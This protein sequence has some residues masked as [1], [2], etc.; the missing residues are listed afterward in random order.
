MSEA[1]VIALLNFA[2]RFGIEAAISFAQRASKPDAT[3]DDVI[4]ALEIAKTKTAKQYLDE[5]KAALPP[6]APAPTA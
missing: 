1:L 2:V 3:L 4:A 6:A 5:A